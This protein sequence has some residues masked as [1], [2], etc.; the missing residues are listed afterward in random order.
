MVGVSEQTNFVTS[1][2]GN[3]VDEDWQLLLSQRLQYADVALR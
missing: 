1:L 2:D 3:H